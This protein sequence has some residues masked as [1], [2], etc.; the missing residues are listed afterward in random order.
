ML[1]SPTGAV[2]KE[3]GDLVVEEAADNIGDA[4][5]PMDEN[6][7]AIP[8][9]LFSSDDFKIEVQNLPRYFGMGS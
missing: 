7:A 8:E 5:E 3:E 2:S 9:K 6:Q 1:D 4:E